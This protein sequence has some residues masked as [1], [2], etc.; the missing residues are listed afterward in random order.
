MIEADETYFGKAETPQPTT[1]P[2][3]HPPIKGGRSGPGSKRAVVALVERGGPARAFHVR[4][5]SAE[6]VADV[7]AKHA[8]P[9][10]RLH[11]DES[12]L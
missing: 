11:T 12:R 2:R 5:V 3:R 6:K 10:S 9:A 1:K 4:R 7:L 8:D